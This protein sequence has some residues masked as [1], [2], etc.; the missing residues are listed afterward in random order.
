MFYFT[1]FQAAVSG[2]IQGITELFPV[3]SLGHSVLVPAW[4]GGSWK[5]GSPS[6]TLFWLL[7]LGTIPVALIGLAPSLLADG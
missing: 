5:R 3:S 4:L 1:F 7:L 6:F 2:L